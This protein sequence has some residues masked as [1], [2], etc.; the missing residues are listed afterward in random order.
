MKSEPYDQKVMH[1]T[2]YSLV[3]MFFCIQEQVS[4]NYNKLHADPK[5]G[6]TLDLGR[7]VLVII[8][9]VMMM[10]V[11]DGSGDDI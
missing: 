5:Q 11:I 6:K 1:E 10:K 3:F 8:I 9:D 4:I 2:C 7:F